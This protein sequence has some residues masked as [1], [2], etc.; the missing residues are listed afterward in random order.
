MGSTPAYGAPTLRRDVEPNF[1]G[2][3]ALTN[4]VPSAQLRVPVDKDYRFPVSVG[5][6]KGV[7]LQ[8]PQ[9]ADGGEVLAGT[10]APFDAGRAALAYGGRR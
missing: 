6:H 3:A 1:V 10:Q 7:F 5:N 2:L 9:G 4:A 8:A